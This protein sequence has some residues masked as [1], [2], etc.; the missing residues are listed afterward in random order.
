MR[1]DTNLPVDTLGMAMSPIQASNGLKKDILGRVFGG[2]EFQFKLIY[3]IKPGTSND[4]R[5]KADELLTS[6]GL[7][8]MGQKPYIGENLSV[9]EISATVNATSFGMY[10]NGDEDHQILMK[11][12][13][14]VIK[15][16]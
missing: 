2:G 3:R 15:N 10:E 6:I 7:W 1:Y 16:G 4:K 8:A 9:V 11:M 14:E 12:N 5:L 13:Y